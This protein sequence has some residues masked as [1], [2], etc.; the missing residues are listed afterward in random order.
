M[1]TMIVVGI[2]ALALVGCVTTRLEPVPLSLQDHQFEVA[3]PRAQ[4]FEALL[5]VA[6]NLNLSVDVLEK[7]SGFIQ[8]KNST[9]TPDQLDRFAQYPYVG[10]TF[11]G[12]S[13]QS[14]AL[15]GGAVRGVASISILLTETAAGTRAKMHATFVASNS[16]ESHQA[17][18]LGV[19][20]HDLEN[21]LRG[22]GAAQ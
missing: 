11:A 2:L 8:F 5:G 12:W 1:K 4:V 21:S 19:L 3:G 17:N 13:R 15:G 16:R 6:Q 14:S 22:A 7:S 18:S 20:E 9:L 10:G